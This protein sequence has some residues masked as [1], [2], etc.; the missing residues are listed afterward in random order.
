MQQ[1]APSETI[2]SEETTAIGQNRQ[3]LGAGANIDQAREIACGQGVQRDVSRSGVRTGT[4]CHGPRDRHLSALKTGAEAA[5]AL[6]RDGITL[7]DDAVGSTAIGEAARRGRVTGDEIEGVALIVVDRRTEAIVELDERRVPGALIDDG[8]K[9]RGAGHIDAAPARGEKTGH[10]GL[11]AGQLEGLD[12][13]EGV[14]I[15]H[16][17]RGDAGRLGADVDASG[18]G[19]EMEISAT[20]RQPAAAVDLV[21]L[22]IMNQ[23]L[24]AHTQQDTICGG[25]H[26]NAAGSTQPKRV[27]R[28]T[29]LEIDSKDLACFDDHTIEHA[30]DWIE[31]EKLGVVPDH[32]D[33]EGTKN[34]L[35][36]HVDLDNVTRE[37]ARCIDQL[38]L[39]IKRD[40]GELQHIGERMP[41]IETVQINGLERHH[42]PLKG[43]RFIAS[44]HPSIGWIVCGFTIHG[45][46]ALGA[47][48]P[49][50]GGVLPWVIK[51][52]VGIH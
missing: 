25:V 27:G 46:V 39:F 26:D 52:I 41:N 35:G 15:Q 1:S 16:R 18:H 33:F 45:G 40:P 22:S 36:R 50:C 8:Q 47:V 13:L 3:L 12:G 28:L 42:L 17:D 31:L 44:T 14:C 5:D 23:N 43:D 21:E 32:V 10:P 34:R 11:A 19:I 37:R 9:R 51:N 38:T 48:R 7:L 24:V 30:R 6:T 2:A 49:A 29:C 4:Q 20:P